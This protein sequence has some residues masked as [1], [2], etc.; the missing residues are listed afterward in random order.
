[1]TP[2]RT[3]ILYLA[4]TALAFAQDDKVTR[5][6]YLVEEVATRIWHFDHG[7][8]EDFKGPYMDFLTEKEKAT[9]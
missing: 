9:A 4:F 7:K 6:K 1:M 2:V 5:G 3:T 8:V